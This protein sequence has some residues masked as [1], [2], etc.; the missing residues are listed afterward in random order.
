MIYLL[1]FSARLGGF[2]RSGAQH[3]LGYCQ[4]RSLRQR[5]RQHAEGQGSAITRAFAAQGIGFV[6]AT[7][8]HP[9]TRAQERQMKA[10]GHYADWC[11][12]CRP[13]EYQEGVTR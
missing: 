2:G 13:P 1:H 9:G 4:E 11:P 6:L 10:R 5:L 8:W 7:I 12:Y 3:Y